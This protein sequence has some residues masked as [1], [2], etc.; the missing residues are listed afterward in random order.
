M[1]LPENKDNFELIDL[2][3]EETEDK[4]VISSKPVIPI[5]NSD[6]EPIKPETETETETEPE[7]KPL[8]KLESKAFAGEVVGILDGVATFALPTFCKNKLFK[9]KTEFNQAKEL[10][11]NSRDKSV[12]F[13]PE[14]Q[15]LIDKY[16]DYRD[17]SDEIPLSD[18]EKSRITQP[19]SDVIFKYQK[20]L[21]CE[22]M[23]VFAVVS[24]YAP[25]TAT[26]IFKK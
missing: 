6:F 2:L 21:S 23:L 14:E 26:L 17:F 1:I 22:W 24:I 8:T 18:P 4:T 12:A 20:R 25:K 13:T 7:Y 10:A 9:N 15:T 11:R 3:S 19:L 5:D 16:H